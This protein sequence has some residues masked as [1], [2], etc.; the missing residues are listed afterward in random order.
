ML[1]IS[2]GFGK[3]PDEVPD[4]Q[5]PEQGLPVY[6]QGEISELKKFTSFERQKLVLYFL[7][8]IFNACVYEG[9]VKNC[10]K[11]GHITNNYYKLRYNV[12]DLK[13]TVYRLDF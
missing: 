6:I 2:D 5:V 12:F 1:S 3:F 13:V 8:S 11:V 4:V 7:S 9:T 10:L